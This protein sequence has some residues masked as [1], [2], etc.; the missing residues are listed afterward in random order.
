[1]VC[2]HILAVYLDVQTDAQGL[3]FTPLNYYS[4]T[5]H[6]MPAFPDYV[7]SRKNYYCKLL[8]YKQEK[9]A[10]TNA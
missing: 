4:T 1:M 7:N 10:V 6:L 9:P 5:H 3:L 8:A 2:M